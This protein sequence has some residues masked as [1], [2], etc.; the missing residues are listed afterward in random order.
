MHIGNEGPIS[1]ERV[2]PLYNAM[3]ALSY[4]RDS[5]DAP[6]SLFN[7]LVNFEP[8]MI[9]A[10]SRF[11]SR[12]GNPGARRRVKSFGRSLL[13]QQREYTRE[14]IKGMMVL[15]SVNGQCYQMYKKKKKVLFQIT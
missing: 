7:L 14:Y 3:M 15:R 4:H 6:R 10:K 9:I 1:S 8:P 11:T 13:I 2:K 5:H 12:E